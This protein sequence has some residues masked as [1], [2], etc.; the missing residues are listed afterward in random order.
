M[1]D[2]TALSNR[3]VALL[4]R[5]V[6]GWRPWAI[7]V[8]LCLCL[9]LP[10]L[11][12]MPPLDRDEAR[13]MQAT[14]Q[15]LESGD[16]IRIR[17]QEEARNKKP[18]GIYWLQA[19]SVRIF[20]DPASSAAWPY[21]LPSVLGATAAVLATFAL[22]GLVG[23]PAA[24]LGAA[25]LAS[26]VMLVA[27]AHLAK[28]DAALLASTVA[29]Q[30]A[31]AEVY[32]RARTGTIAPPW[33]AVVFWLAQG[34]GILLK[35]P[36]TPLVSAL[37]VIA[38]GIADR[39]W[40]WLG[41]LRAARGIPLAVVMV[42][43]WLVAIQ[44][45]TGGAFAG[46]AIG[47][48]LLGKLVGAQEAHGAPPGSYLLLAPATFWPSSALFG[49]AGLAAWRRRREVAERFLLAWLIPSWLLFELVPTKL[50]H[51][52]L[53]LY[54]ALALLAGV[55]L[56]AT[57]NGEAVERKRWLEGVVLALWGMIGLALIIG[58]IAL[59]IMLGGGI[60]V[61]SLIPTAAIVS[62]GV[63][64]VRQLDR[65]F[66]VGAAPAI[67]VTALLV[68]VPSF[69]G[70]LPGLDGLWLSRSAAA[71]VARHASPGDTIDTVGY[72]EPSLVFLLGGK[73]LAVQAPQAAADLASH[74]G[75]LALVAGR[76]EEP[77]RQAL[78]AQGARPAKLDEASGIDYSR[79]SRK[80]TLSLYAAAA[81]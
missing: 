38:L 71:M 7:L 31:L 74:P 10:G 13:F 37:T 55:A 42:L 22:A 14:R 69:A 47:H 19:A 57:V 16:L 40:R 77:F 12:A 58:L 20:S 41:G 80:M 49:I 76:E 64:L 56:A 61:L 36:V 43:P 5:L 29:A 59:P 78:E 33:V 4:E 21:R 26:C 2:S 1:S 44:T 70:L 24:L 53:P 52:I 18:A 54:P 62:F 3:N 6:V 15:M 30:A 32:R 63:I 72:N 79:S 66:W 34:A 28:T 50:P 25:L 9:Y 35:G 65:G 17:F 75:A 51:Y 27:E 73:T 68:F 23:R 39:R 46:E 45:A 60:T 8:A 11:A 81:R 67:V 48:D